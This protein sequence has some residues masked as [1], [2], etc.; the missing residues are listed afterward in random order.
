MGSRLRIRGLIMRRHRNPWSAP[1]MPTVGEIAN[2]MWELLED[3]N[4][5]TRFAGD[6]AHPTDD[7][8]QAWIEYYHQALVSLP[9][10][11]QPYIEGEWDFFPSPITL[12]V[13]ARDWDKVG[14]DAGVQE[15]SNEE[16]LHVYYYVAEDDGEN[17]PEEAARKLPRRRY[18]PLYILH[19]NVMNY[20]PE[21]LDELMAER[22]WTFPRNEDNFDA[23]ILE[24]A[25][26]DPDGVISL[27]EDREEYGKIR[28]RFPGS[29]QF[30]GARH[31]GW[32][33]DL[34]FSW[35]LT[36]YWRNALGLPAR[37]RNRRRRRRRRSLRPGEIGWMIMHTTLGMWWNDF[38][39]MWYQDQSE[40]TIFIMPDGEGA[41]ETP[42]P[43]S[44][45]WVHAASGPPDQGE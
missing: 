18:E 16:G 19:D 22:N 34:D 30:I 2:R 39:T 14:A 45:E 25:N 13:L 4:A 15:K 17:E 11:L 32:T 27:Q 37:P 3:N 5:A 44:G 28:Q 6:R 12:M 21:F 7:E 10:P 23:N 43:P 42:L 40:G 41:P 38:D 33:D 1:P 35:W 29:W 20:G 26:L 9:A 8:I 36:P 24:E 31:P